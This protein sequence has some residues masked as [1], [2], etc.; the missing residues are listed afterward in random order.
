MNHMRMLCLLAILSFAAGAFAQG[1]AKPTAP[2]PSPAPASAP[3]AQAT[4]APM[5]SFAALAD[6]Q[7]S[8]YEKNVVE[9]AEA[10]LP[11]LARAVELPAVARSKAA[12]LHRQ[13][14]RTG[15]DQKYSDPARKT[16]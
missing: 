13:S 11:G 15:R 10:E 2:A 5:T 12:R 4:P 6:R 14:S 1:G 8:Q 9:A 3:Q 7:V 16:S